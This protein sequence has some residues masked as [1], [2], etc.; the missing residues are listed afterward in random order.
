MSERKDRIRIQI[1]DQEFNVVGGTFQEMLSAVKQIN[2]RR[3]VSELKVWQLPGP[4]EEVQRQLEIS[5]YS[6]EGG[7]PVASVPP[8]ASTPAGAAGDRIRVLVGGQRLA[9]V[10]G[11]FQDM[12]AVVKGLPGRRF[13]SDT[14]LWEISGDPGVIKGMIEAAGFQL[15]GAEKIRLD[16]VPPMEMPNF[17]GHTTPSPYHA[18]DFFDEPDEAPEPPP[19][20]DDELA[21]PPV[22]NDFFNEPMFEQEP[23][24][25]R[26]KPAMAA[27][28]AAVGAAGRRG[29]DRVRIRLGE[30]PLVV[31]GGEFQAILALVKSIP[32]RRFNGDERVWEIPETVGLESLGQRVAA[33][34][35]VLE[36][37]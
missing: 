5:G 29:G 27:P 17:S 37:E 9:V 36:Q 20:W 33:A 19:W 2:G 31:S 8:A 18:S 24:P 16:P 4:A 25:A 34:G 7:A 6:L 11:N 15:E 26:P 30:M 1:G 12:L 28:A 23:P 3:F 10:G 32:G 21:P 35:F 13:D 14:K 22:A